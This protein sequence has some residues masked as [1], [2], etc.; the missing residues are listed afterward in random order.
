MLRPQWVRL[1]GQFQTVSERFGLNQSVSAWV[2]T[3]V[4]ET[5]ALNVPAAVE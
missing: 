3:C 5:N 2:F 1:H 4:D